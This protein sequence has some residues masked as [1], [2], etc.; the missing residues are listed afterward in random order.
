[1]EEF[2][3]DDFPAVLEKVDTA[4]IPTTM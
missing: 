3:S 1:M 2:G 4:L